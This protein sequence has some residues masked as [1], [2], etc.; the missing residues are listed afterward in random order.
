[1]LLWAGKHT[2]NKIRCQV[3]TPVC[4][5]RSSQN[6]LTQFKPGLILEEQVY[7]WRKAGKAIRKFR[8]TGKNTGNVAGNQENAIL[9]SWTDEKNSEESWKRHI[10]SA[11]SWKQ[12]PYSWPS[13]SYGNRLVRKLLC[14]PVCE[15]D[16][17]QWRS[18]TSWWYPSDPCVYNTAVLDLSSRH[19][20]PAA[21]LL[22]HGLTDVS[23]CPTVTDYARPNQTSAH[24][25]EKHQNI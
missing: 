16:P 4:V 24:L 13:F 1:M 12:T 9:E 6:A 25:T 20:P 3:I 18:S 8:K 23:A 21:G 2:S 5:Q 22:L 7:F 10:F 15:W 11:E 14:I 17:C 19:S